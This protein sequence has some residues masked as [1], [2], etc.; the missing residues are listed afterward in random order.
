MPLSTRVEMLAGARRLLPWAAMRGSA[1]VILAACGGG[2]HMTVGD[3]TVDVDA[4]PAASCA[5]PG[6]EAASSGQV[7]ALAAQRCNVSGSMGSSHWYRLLGSLPSGAM[8]IIQLELWPNLGSFAGGA[9][10][11][12]TFT[13]AG[14]D[15]DYTK[16]G[17]CVRAV[18]KHGD[19]ANQT[20]Y[21]ATAGTVTVTSFGDAPT[22]FTATIA[23]ATFEE[24]D[25][26]G[27]KS[28]AC[29]TVVPSIEVSGPTVNK[30]GTGGGGGG[31][32]GSGA[33]GCVRT[34]GDI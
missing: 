31:G 13:I 27:A 1:F 19:T 34:V 16:C 15:A 33:G 5:L 12:G 26:N 10:H 28:G 25:A 8:D 29:V 14:D 17:V 7:T 4:P 6:P 18:G 2:G 32:G 23:N 11:T 22:A 24:V 30:G 20:L 9:V 3:D 21:F